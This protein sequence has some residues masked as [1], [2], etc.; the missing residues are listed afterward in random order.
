MKN[1]VEMLYNLPEGF[2]Y[3]RT[4]EY[5]NEFLLRFLKKCAKEKKD[6]F[7]VGFHHYIEE[8]GD[9]T[10]NICLVG[11]YKIFSMCVFTDTPTPHK[12]NP[13]NEFVA[14]ED[15]DNFCLWTKIDT[16]TNQFTSDS[17]YFLRD[18]MDGLDRAIDFIIKEFAYELDV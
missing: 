13:N 4:E 7:I 9:G 12:S 16:E 6:K 5:W 3:K 14:D 18:G 11:P 15:N 17:F 8:D 10:E 1:V 2:K